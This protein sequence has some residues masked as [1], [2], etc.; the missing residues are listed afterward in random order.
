MAKQKEIELDENF[1]EF[2][3]LLNSHKVKYLLVGGFAVGLHGYPRHTGDLDIWVRPDL[4]NGI[5]ILA[6]LKQFGFGSLGL[7][8]ESFV[9]PDII[10]QFG[11]APLRIDVLTGVSGLTFDECFARKQKM[12]LG[13]I[14]VNV[15]HLND[16]KQ[17]KLSSGRP[18]DLYDVK[19]L[20][21]VESNGKKTSKRKK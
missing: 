8:T 11:Y 7:T 10:H 19:K 13:G 3:A 20:E 14:N 21:Q 15:V 1:K 5:K 16:L 4:N 18:E 6:V 12:R 9:K 2:I 17:N